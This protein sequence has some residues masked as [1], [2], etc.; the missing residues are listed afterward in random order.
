MS[1][2]RFGS[3]NFGFA[4]VLLLSLAAPAWASHPIILHQFT[5]D[6]DVS[7]LGVTGGFAGTNDLHG[8]DGTFAL[9]IGF[10]EVFDPIHGHALVPFASF[11][12]VDAVLTQPGLLEGSDLDGLL[13][14]TGLNGTFAHSFDFAGLLFT[15]VDGQGQPIDV[16][17]TRQNN[18]LRL[19]GENKAGCCDFFNF[20]L[21][22]YADIPMGGD[23][24]QDGHVG[25]A[26]LNMVLSDFGN[27]V[28]PMTG[29][30]V[31]W[32]GYVGITDL[33]SVLSDWNAGTTGGGSL[34]IPEPIVAGLLL[35]GIACWLLRRRG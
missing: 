29:G 22:A 15:G 3:L 25:I 21:D 28:A 8:I 30:D 20:R 32:D 13:N 9:A 4:A 1:A 14:L 2:A 23:L 27:T 26:D 11:A 12:L 16:R 7:T 33:N 18:Q 6:T 19:Q 34:T 5:F 10:D 17:V 35:P 24:N 31:D